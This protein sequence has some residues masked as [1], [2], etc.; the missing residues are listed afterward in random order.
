MRWNV[1]VV[2]Y[3]IILKIYN[4]EKFMKWKIYVVLLYNINV[5]KFYFYWNEKYLFIVCNLIINVNDC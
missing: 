2:L 1:C 4:E 3:V 5:W